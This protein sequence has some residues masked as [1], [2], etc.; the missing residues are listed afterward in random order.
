MKKLLDAC[1]TNFVFKS[2]TVFKNIELPFINFLTKFACRVIYSYIVHIKYKNT[3][4]SLINFFYFFIFKG[5]INTMYLEDKKIKLFWINL[6]MSN[7]F[8]EIYYIFFH[9]FFVERKQN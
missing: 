7:E 9:L 5:N 4:L 6:V 2:N 1:L 8:Y 3:K